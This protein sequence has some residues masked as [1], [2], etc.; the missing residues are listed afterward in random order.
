MR[1]FV[2]FK[3][4]TA[5]AQLCCASSA[6]LK[7]LKITAGDPLTSPEIVT[8]ALNHAPANVLTESLLLELHAALSAIAAASPGQPESS[9][10]RRRRI[11]STAAK[12]SKT[13]SCNVLGTKLPTAPRGIVLTSAVAGVFSGGLDLSVIG[14]ADKIVDA[15]TFRSYWS[16]FQ[17]VWIL[18][19]DLP[20]PI[21]CA[22]H[23]QCPAAGCILATACDARIMA[24]FASPRNKTTT[25]IEN[26][27]GITAARG[28]FC[29]PPWAAASLAHVVGPR[30]AEHLLGTGELLDATAALNCGL[31]DAVI[32]TA[33]ANEVDEAA[34]AEAQRYAAPPQS[35]D[36][37]FRQPHTFWLVK[38]AARHRVLATLASDK[39]R[40]ED[41]L[42]FHEMLS[43]PTVRASIAQYREQLSLRQ[44]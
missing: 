21:V 28:G 41:T 36:D 30:I 8:V 12:K 20:L 6:A 9:Q 17:A 22:I 25:F 1:R 35:D 14:Q 10:P 42:L 34:V 26:R 11:K 29:A 23:G 15:E 32:D 3:R 5:Q 37:D 13:S 43:R 7:H 24:K 44:R 40:A 33:G 38:S 19:N 31:V 4:H 2:T 27:I 39:A 18:L 16:A